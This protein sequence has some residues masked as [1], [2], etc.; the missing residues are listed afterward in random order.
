MCST[1]NP[2]LILDTTILW[3]QICIDLLLDPNFRKRRYVGEYIYM[4]YAYILPFGIC[5]PSH[6][7]DLSILVLVI[8][9][10]AI[11]WCI[12]IYYIHIY[13]YI[14]IYIL[15]VYGWVWV[16]I[17]TCTSTHM[18]IYAPAN[19][20]MKSFVRTQII[21]VWYIYLHLPHKWPKCRQIFHTW[22]IWGIVRPLSELVSGSCSSRTQIQRRKYWSPKTWKRALKAIWKIH[23]CWKSAG[24]NLLYF[25]WSQPWIGKYQ[26]RY[27]EQRIPEIWTL[28]WP[29]Q[30]PKLEVLYHIFGHIF[31]GYSTDIRLHK[32]WKI[33]LTYG[34]YLQSSSDPE[35]WSNSWHIN[36][37]P[38][39]E[40]LVSIEALPGHSA[41][42]TQG[43]TSRARP[44]SRVR[45]CAVSSKAQHRSSLVS[46]GL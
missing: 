7:V 23:L 6:M 8:T 30:E 1:D 28:H 32:A 29:F 45:S 38:H 44:R 12:I 46:L 31:W 4:V 11:I 22:M 16:T 20:P 37:S 15:Y 3:S 24:K 21:H 10:E 27:Y 41:C 40:Q 19:A 25:A 2:I 34:R 14:Y 17:R 5:F 43:I 9:R 42:S 39:T 13:T 36:D 18:H 33:G 26:G 35:S